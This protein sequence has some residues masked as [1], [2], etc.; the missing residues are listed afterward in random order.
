MFGHESGIPHKYIIDLWKSKCFEIL[1][2]RKRRLDYVLFLGID[3][4]GNLHKAV[5]S[6]LYSECLVF[7]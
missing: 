1:L 5:S 6:I 3:F 4:S 7:L 2:G